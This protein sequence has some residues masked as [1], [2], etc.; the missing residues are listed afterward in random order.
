MDGDRPPLPDKKYDMLPLSC[1][2][3]QERRS[4]PSRLMAQGVRL[5][6]ESYSARQRKDYPG[7]TCIGDLSRVP[8]KVF[9]EFF[10]VGHCPT[11]TTANRYLMIFE[12]EGEQSANRRCLSPDSR[13]RLSGVL[14]ESLASLSER[15]LLAALGNM[16]PVPLIGVVL[17]PLLLRWAEVM[18]SG[19]TPPPLP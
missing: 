4:A 15:D 19:G 17:K 9:G 5:N 13:A 16:I 1:F 3:E 8:G 7:Q 2:L 14:P 18:R 6:A 10:S 12:D 11:L